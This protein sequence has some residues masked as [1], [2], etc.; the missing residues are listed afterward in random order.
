[1]TTAVQGLGKKR[2]PVVLSTEPVAGRGWI[3]SVAVHRP[4]KICTAFLNLQ[5]FLREGLQLYFQ[6]AQERKNVWKGC[7]TIASLL[8]HHI[9]QVSKT[10]GSVGLEAN[11]KRGEFPGGTFSSQRFYHPFY[12]V[13]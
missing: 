6:A 12:L 11:Y 5:E 4:L 13:L 1:M 10:G 8:V 3:Y 2:K 9:Q 7:R